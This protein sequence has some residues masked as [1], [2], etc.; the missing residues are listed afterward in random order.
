MLRALGRCCPTIAVPGNHDVSWWYGPLKVGAYGRLLERYQRYIS[1]E[2]EPTLVAPGRDVGLGLVGI[3]T[4]HG[5]TP[6]TLTWN[7]RDLSIIG[8]VTPAQLARTREKMAA[9]PPDYCK[10]IVMHHNP[11]AGRLSQRYGLKHPREVLR[12]LA[13]MGV[14]LV[15]CG[16][17]HEEQASVHEFDGRRIVVSTAGTLSDRSRGGRPSSYNAITVS[18]TEIAVEMRP[19]SSSSNDFVAGPTLCFAR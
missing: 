3:N 9:L 13:G 19:W 2:I 1:P 14:E 4:A 18:A 7:L 5:I 15:L 12:A 6:R 10:V 17:D 16:H 11:V 8:D